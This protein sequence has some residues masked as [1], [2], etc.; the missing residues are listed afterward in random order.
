MHRPTS[1]YF[2]FCFFVAL[3]EYFFRFFFSVFSFQF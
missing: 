2:V 1:G 3:F